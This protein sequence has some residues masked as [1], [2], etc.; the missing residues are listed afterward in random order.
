MI[1]KYP[2]KFIK[3][4]DD[5][6]YYKIDMTGVNKLLALVNEKYQ[7]RIGVIGGGKPRLKRDSF[8]G[9]ELKTK[10]FQSKDENLTNAMI[11]MMHEKGVKSKKLPRRS[12]LQTPLEDHLPEH[13]RKISTKTLANIFR[14]QPKKAYAELGI[15][16]EAIIQ[17]GFETAGYGKWQPLSP[18]T[19]EKKGSSAV[20]IDTAQ[21]RKSITSRV[22]RK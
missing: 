18:E 8:E 10:K 9:Q 21:L 19:I 12:W 13:M 20:L 17:K 5:G 14:T 2:E 16:A 6:S 11:G 1:K 3:R 22:V 15:V 7:V 4:L